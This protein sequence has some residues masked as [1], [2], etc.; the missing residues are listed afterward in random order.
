MKV[1]KALKLIDKKWV[2]KAKGYRVQYQEMVDSALVTAYCPGLDDKELDSDVTTWRLAWK[3]ATSTQ[4]KG[5][6]IAEGELVNVH[7]VD[8]EENPIIYYA[9]GKYDLLNP[10][11]L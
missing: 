3:L 9:T 7:V 10:K 4:T 6:T 5:D 11:D 1:G 2:R 8:D